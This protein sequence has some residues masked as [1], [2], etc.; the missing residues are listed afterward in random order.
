MASCC[1]V[2]GTNRLCWRVNSWLMQ[3]TPR[4]RR[5]RFLAPGF[6]TGIGVWASG[7]GVFGGG[8]MSNLGDVTI[9]Q[10]GI[11]V[12]SSIGSC[13]PNKHN[14]NQGSVWETTRYCLWYFEI[15]AIHTLCLWASEYGP[16]ANSTAHCSS[17]GHSL[18]LQEPNYQRNNDANFLLS[19]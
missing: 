18:A 10:A 17:H 5:C 11:E 19:F 6:Q 9:V 13:L 15:R 1:Y 16:V 8:L 2:L 12:R 7:G 14:F 4:M 3:S